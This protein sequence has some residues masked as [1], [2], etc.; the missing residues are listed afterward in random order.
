[1]PESLGD[2]GEVWFWDFEFTQP[3]GE[4]PQP[5]CMVAYESKSD[6]WLRLWQDEL[7]QCPFST[8]DSSLFV[9]YSSSAEMSCHLSLNWPV[10]V[11]C[12]DLYPEFRNATN[13]LT[14][15]KPNL[16]FALTHFGIPSIAEQEKERWREVAIRGAPFSPEERSGL[17][18][19]CAS[20]VLPLP[21]LLNAMLPFNPKD[22]IRSFQQALQRGRFAKSV[23]AMERY[24]VPVDTVTASEFKAYWPDL[25]RAMIDRVNPDYDV[26]DGI[27]FKLEKFQAYLDKRGW[28]WPKTP[29]GRLSVDDDVFKDMANTHP[30]LLPLKELRATV[31]GAMRLGPKLAI[32]ADNRN[33][34]SIKPFT[35]SSSRNAPSSAEFLFGPA[36]WLRHLIK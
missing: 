28:S 23:A 6:R 16:L 7:E 13:G 25:K 4:R 36:V 11:H 34:T 17:L 14:L 21:R 22:P 9:A 27:V 3:K 24:G 1:M 20:D 31:N 5:I 10:P 35:A 12:I 26:Y 33:R 8:G 30:E 32:G 15:K 19:Y 18:E 2:F 29:T